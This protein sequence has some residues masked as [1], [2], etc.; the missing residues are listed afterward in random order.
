MILVHRS[1][2]HSNSFQNPVRQL[3]VNVGLENEHQ[4][5]FYDRDCQARHLRKEVSI[6]GNAPQ[7]YL[8][9]RRHCDIQY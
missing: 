5:S 4:V 6:S 7:V 1:Q 3:E 9:V 8:G 2:V